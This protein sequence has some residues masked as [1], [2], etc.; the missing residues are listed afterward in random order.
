MTTGS[1][2]PGPCPDAIL[3]RGVAEKEAMDRQDSLT[4]DADLR[5]LERSRPHRATQLLTSIIDSPG[6]VALVWGSLP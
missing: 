5:R 6:M 2:R 3:T 1:V 4:D